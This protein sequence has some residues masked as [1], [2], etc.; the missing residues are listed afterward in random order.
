MLDRKDRRCVGRVV[1]IRVQASVERIG[2]TLYY[3]FFSLYN[4]VIYGFDIL[5]AYMESAFT[6][7]PNLLIHNLN[8]YY[9]RWLD[10]NMGVCNSLSYR[11]LRWIRA[12]K[13][14][15]GWLTLFASIYVDERFLIQR[16]GAEK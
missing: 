1:T 3:L 10:V 8:F 15:P 6:N 13:F 4:G 16:K 5:S 2:L 11:I 14:L 9:A 7:D 12:K